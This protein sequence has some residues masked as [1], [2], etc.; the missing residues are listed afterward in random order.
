MLIKNKAPGFYYLLAFHESQIHWLPVEINTVG[1]EDFIA[2][3]LVEPF[4]FQ[5][6]TNQH[7]LGLM[8]IDW[9][10]SLASI[11]L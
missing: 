1:E 10:I 4:T 9:E 6:G 2:M 3:I 5:K 7:G 8:A 11:V